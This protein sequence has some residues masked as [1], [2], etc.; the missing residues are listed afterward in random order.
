MKISKKL[1]Q[2]SKN[3]R[4]LKQVLILMLFIPFLFS[5][6]T[7]SGQTGTVNIS[8]SAIIVADPPN[9]PVPLSVI[10]NGTR[11]FDPDGSI[12][13]YSWD[14]GD[15]ERA[16]GEYA[17]HTYK[18]DG[19]YVVTLTVSDNQGATSS[20]SITILAGSAGNC[21]ISTLSPS[22]FP[23]Y[24]NNSLAWDGAA[25][26]NTGKVGGDDKNL[27]KFEPDGKLIQP[28]FSVGK[29]LT[30][31]IYIYFNFSD[32]VWDGRFLVGVDGGSLIYM[33]RQG[34][35]QSDL[36]I[37]NAPV[38][39]LMLRGITWDGTSLWVVGEGFQGTQKKSFLMELGGQGTVKRSVELVVQGIE[40]LA[41]DGVALWAINPSK[42]KLY[43]IDR[44]TGALQISCDLPMSNP[45]GLTW[46]GVY[47]W[48]LTSTSTI[49][50]L[51]VKPPEGLGPHF[52]IES[53]QAPSSI[54]LNQSV[55][56][57]VTVKNTSS[58]G[59]YQNVS[60]K[61]KDDQ[62]NIIK[63]VINSLA[64][65]SFA[66]TNL[67]FTHTFV[68][69]GSY[70]AEFA[71]QDDLRSSVVTAGVTP[72]LVRFKGKIVNTR[73]G[74][75]EIADVQVTQ[76]LQGSISGTVSI[77]LGHDVAPGCLGKIDPSLKIGDEIEVY[78]SYD[79]SSG[80]V[81]VC[82]SPNYSV[83]LTI[84]PPPSKCELEVID[85]FN[86]G[87]PL[88]G[89]AYANGSLYGWDRTSQA[90]IK[91]DVKSKAGQTLNTGKLS[92]VPRG[93]GSDLTN[94]LFITAS[95]NPDS[96]YP[97]AKINPDSLTAVGSPI[98]LPDRFI[99][100]DDLTWDGAYFWILG[101][102]YNPPTGRMLFKISSTGQVL[103]SKALPDFAPPYV[104]SITSDKQYLYGADYPNAKIYRFNKDTGE[105]VDTCSPAPIIPDSSVPPLQGLAWD[106]TYF[107]VSDTE[108]MVYK[109]K[110]K[111]GGGGRGLPP[112]PFAVY[113]N[114]W[115]SSLQDPKAL[116]K[117]LKEHNVN[118]IFI[119]IYYANSQGQGTLTIK[120]ISPKAKAELNV[121]V[122]DHP[123]DFEA[124]LNEA[125]SANIQV[126]TTVRTFAAFSNIAGCYIG[127]AGWIDPAIQEHRQHV[128]EVVKF[129]TQFTS[130]AGINLDYIRYEC[131]GD[132]RANSNEAWIRVVDSFVAEVKEVVHPGKLLSAA[133]FPAATNDEYTNRSY[134]VRDCY[135]Q[136]Y[137]NMGSHM[138][139]IMPMTYHLNFAK[140]YTWVGEVVSFIKSKVAIPVIP[141]IQ[142]FDQE[143]N[144]EQK[145]R[146]EQP[147]RATPQEIS[148]A[149]LAARSKAA[150]GIAA[151]VL[152]TLTMERWE[153][154]KSPACSPSPN[155]GG[156]KR[157]DAAIAQYSGSSIFIEDA[158]ILWA[159]SLWIR[160]QIVPGT[161]E[162]ISDSKMLDLLSKWIKKTLIP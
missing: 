82:S 131:K 19:R 32:V 4:L 140:P 57:T 46:D 113:I 11:S 90:L 108:G 152:G 10:F 87:V 16:S 31:G 64:L 142:A 98:N 126:H 25:L 136:D 49:H 88:Q 30:S 50:K 158:D 89:L 33:T 159:I 149:V 156:S 69:S 97:I 74:I 130:L 43:R 147:K 106:G 6:F 37:T 114:P 91:V 53:F 85:S 71:T 86:T 151:F 27:A 124:L 2:F 117:R 59:A 153:A 93:V 118:M 26:W 154:L 119:P 144:E 110:M 133:V 128:R 40:D 17:S 120:N 39:S 162:T 13:S 155:G 83:Q 75:V 35:F 62:G 94:L 60:W 5:P 42:A 137:T 101:S 54:N 79:S 95:T 61:V 160:G 72:S 7:S 123:F 129:L 143:P 145:K 115:D 12:T 77:A 8:P 56:F 80:T 68:T 38:V 107:W 20:S 66:Q 44:D 146:G 116:V 1:F 100:P 3:A 45:S 55:T 99:A 78:G 51:L 58:V 96:P 18:N 157:L 36:P 125:N 48:V 161:N 138:D 111:G 112:S 109:L 135:G 134:G 15:G 52:K 9:G 148:C 103:L 34:S 104:E 127:E 29:R 105:F 21:G 102:L 122:C 139:F 63:V 65:D 121:K 41:W 28:I 23:S 70:T 14:F 73:S 76:V 150:D 141:I 67:S 84:T 47:F 92:L 132:S 22:P 24:G 81:D